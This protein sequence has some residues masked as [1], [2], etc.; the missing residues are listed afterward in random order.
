MTTGVVTRSLYVSGRKS[1][2]L[3]MMSKSPARSNT[4]AMCRHSAT[5]ASIVASS[6]QPQGV[7]ACRPAVVIESAVANSV[8]WW[9]AA[10]SPSVSN[11]A[12]CSH[13]P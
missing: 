12:N 3:W 7:V 6:D 9:P 5:L 2:P 11:E 10:T 8:T 13:G 4:E 1:N